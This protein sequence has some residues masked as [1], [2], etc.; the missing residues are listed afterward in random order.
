MNSGLRIL[1]FDFIRL[2]CGRSVGEMR[3]GYELGY[4]IKVVR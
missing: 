2:I 4:K 1:S 3:Q